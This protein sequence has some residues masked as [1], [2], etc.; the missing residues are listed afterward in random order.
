MTWI[1]WVQSY[2]SVQLISIWIM[3][4][5]EFHSLFRI[6]FNYLDSDVL[7]LTL[8]AEDGE[9][10][11]QLCSNGHN[12]CIPDLAQNTRGWWCPN[13]SDGSKYSIFHTVQL[14]CTSIPL[15]N[16]WVEV[17]I[18]CIWPYVQCQREKST[19]RYTHLEFVVWK[20]I[21]SDI[22]LYY[23]FGDSI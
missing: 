17:K 4:W 16:F 22:C 7:P 6:P 1:I 14:C 15:S 23:V 12:W 11:F 3:K 2:D 10:C 19:N 9:R 8:I 5:I 18:I 13:I 20:T 21:S